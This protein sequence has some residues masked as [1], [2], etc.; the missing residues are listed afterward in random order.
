MFEVCV[1]F[2]QCKGLGLSWD[3]GDGEGKEGFGVIV[4]IRGIIFDD[5][6]RG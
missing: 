5:K 3:G 2:S 6:E 1:V 4:G